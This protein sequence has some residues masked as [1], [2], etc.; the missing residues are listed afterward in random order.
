MILFIDQTGQIG[1]AELCLADIAGHYG[2]RARVVLFA[3]GPFEALLRERGVA[4]EVLPM[5][6]GL[7]G[8]TK[9][10]GKRRL[11]A[12]FPAL[13]S[14]V[15]ALRRCRRDAELLYLNTAK[16]LLQGTAANLLP[17]RPCV[18]H[19]HDLWD[20]EH[21]SGTNIR[22]LVAAANR[23]DAVI[24]NSRATAE[25][26][27]AAGGRAPVHVIPNG[28]DPGVFDA[29]PPARVEELRREG[30]PEG[31]V[32][33]AIFG[34]LARWKGQ[35]VL[36]RAA[37][38]IPDLAVWVVGE[39][40]FTEDDRAYAA[41]LHSLARDAGG[42]VR[43]LGFRRDVPALMRA[44]D[45]VVHASRAAEPF[46]R[47]LVEGMLCGRPVVA[48]SAGGPRDI[49]EDGGTGLLVPP[50]DSAALTAALERL[51]LSPA[52]RKDMGR[53]GRERAE[54]LYALPSILRKTDEVMASVMSST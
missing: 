3:E 34:R 53:R 4:V 17:R 10:A 54:T 15:L 31:R 9:Q 28:F 37:E 49:V 40:L 38:R 5:G 11:L 2:H 6:G 41:E 51:V 45:I 25:T 19:L 7:S 44:A 52:L 30:N 1:G 13:A 23:V 42:R 8:V 33:A 32:V 22:L 21:F 35:D 26:F 29:V 18:F 14:H 12:G 43:F 20:R 46:G 16:A 36:L 48:S 50:G 27:R 24:A 47:V 39:A